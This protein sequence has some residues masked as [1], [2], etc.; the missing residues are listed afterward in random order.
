[1]L[2]EALVLGRDDGR[3]DAVRD[4]L[5]GQIEAPLLGILGDQLAVGRMHAGHHRRLV[6]GQHVIIGK[7]GREPGD[8]PGG[9]RC[10][11]E[12]EHGTNPE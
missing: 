12:K 9:D 7:I 11:R 4:C 1:M 8:V 5:D 10:N 6:L 2:V 3:L